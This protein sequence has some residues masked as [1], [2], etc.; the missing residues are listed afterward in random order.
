MK[1][2]RLLTALFFLIASLSFGANKKIKITCSENDANIYSNGNL[3]GVG[4]AVVIVPAYGEVTV[5][6]KKTGFID[7]SKTF[8][9]DN[10]H[11]PP[12]S[13]TIIL[14][15][16]DSYEASSSSDQANVN[17]EIKTSKSEDVAWR[18]MTEIITSKFD[19]LEVTDKSTG[20]LKTGWVTQSF[21]QNTVRTMLVVHPSNSNP[22]TY[23]VKII[24][25]CSGSSDT[26]VKADEKFKSW[27]RILR[28]YDDLIPELQSRLK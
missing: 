7:E 27:D 13:Y 22:L 19:I 15:K 10:S 17:I 9:N 4:E 6:A 5:M 11:R 18:L 21:K 2:S 24:S 1:P 23:K 8:Y 3:V 20:Y 26:S 12:S 25:E 16:D 14:T 28:K